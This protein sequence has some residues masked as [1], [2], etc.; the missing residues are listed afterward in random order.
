VQAAQAPGQRPGCPQAAAG[1]AT[2]RQASAGVPA[3]LGG[4]SG[5]SAE[6]GSLPSAGPSIPCDPG[7]IGI[8]G[9][10]LESVRPDHGDTQRKALPRI[11]WVH[12]AYEAI[13]PPE[14]PGLAGCHRGVQSACPGQLRESE[15]GALRLRGS[16]E[17]P[18]PLAS[19]NRPRA[20]DSRLHA[21]EHESAAS[22]ASPV[23]A[24]AAD[25]REIAGVV[26]PG[27][28]DHAT[29]VG[30]VHELEATSFHRVS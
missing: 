3:R 26:E 22:A 5:L 2:D 27:K 24:S 8:A 29:G 30:R 10:L 20:E 4:L 17:R 16:V 11:Q 23:L 1:A 13:L 19:H 28:S 18:A 25:E 21:P 6:M 14:R 7:V 15:A 9:G 12:R